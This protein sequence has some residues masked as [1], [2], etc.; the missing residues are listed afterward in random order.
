MKHV[1]QVN[2]SCLTKISL[3]PIEYHG[4]RPSLGNA[5]LLL[6]DIMNFV[7]ECRE[8]FWGM[9]GHYICTLHHKTRR[10]GYYIFPLQDRAKASVIPNF[11]YLSI[12]FLNC[13]TL[14]LHPTSKL[15]S[16]LFLWISCTEAHGVL[17]I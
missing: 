3:K 13:F 8:Q 15:F 4:L 5:S 10:F 17:F 9:S 12:N 2:Q 14:K 16:I 11:L 1:K 6:L 7:T